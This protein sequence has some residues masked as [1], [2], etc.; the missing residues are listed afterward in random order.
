MT[1]T[2][3][4]PA[5]ASLINTPPRKRRRFWRFAGIG[6]LS[7]VGLVLLCGAVSAVSSRVGLARGQESAAVVAAQQAA[8]LNQPVGNR[9]PAARPAALGE[10]ERTVVSSGEPRRYV[11][12]VPSGYDPARQTALVLSLHGSGSSAEQQR[13]YS[14]WSVFA[15]TQNFVVVYPE[16]SELTN[17]T[18]VSFRIPDELATDD[19]TAEDNLID[20][21]YMEDVLAQVQAELCIDPDRIYLNGFSA[22]ASM[23]LLM[24][25]RLPD[26]FA[27]IGTVSAAFWSDLADPAWCPDGPT[28]PLIAFHGTADRVIPYEGGGPPV[29]FTFINHE[30]WTD[31]WAADRAGC[32]LPPEPF[33]FAP[34]VEGARYRGCRDGNEVVRYRIDGGGHAWPGGAPIMDMMLGKTTTEIVATEQMWDFFTRQSAAGGDAA[35]N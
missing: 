12:F 18:F 16:A 14:Q 1:Q 33:A 10:T 5:D 9:C 23:T 25:C 24:A 34:S 4:T 29:G 17:K 28:P 20:V 11:Q 30:A 8:T 19:V 27:A 15:E 7:L 32:A 35:G 31:A 21:V 13:D 6:C 26:T 22:G 3:D 2:S